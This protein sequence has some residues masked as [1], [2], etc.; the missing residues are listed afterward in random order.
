MSRVFDCFL[1]FNEI[2]LLELRLNE[3]W[4]GIELRCP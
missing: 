4:D 2:D 1:I 3:L